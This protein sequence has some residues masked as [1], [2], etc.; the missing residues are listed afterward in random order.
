VPLSEREKRILDE[1]EKQLY[2]EDPSF[3][4]TVRRRVPRMD[5][6][7]RAKL[8]VLLFVFGLVS[9]LAFFVWGSL[10]AG[11]FA[12]AAMVAGIVLVAGS[13]RGLS[14]SQGARGSRPREQLGRMLSEWE[15]RVRQRY[16]RL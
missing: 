1:I 13:L 15:Q 9:L 10:P 4:R 7:R 16:K 3:A 11:V 6:A 12:F 5:D 14:S 2:E 8:G